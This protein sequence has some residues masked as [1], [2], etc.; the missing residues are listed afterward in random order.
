M[1][2][3]KVGVSIVP[4]VHHTVKFKKSQLS[5][6]Y[7]ELLIPKS[8]VTSPGFRPWTVGPDR[9]RD[10]HYNNIQSDLLLINYVHGQEDK[11]G[12]KLR[13]WDGTSPYHVNRPPRLPRGRVVETKD[14]KKRTWE[15]VPEITGVSINIFSEAAKTSVEAAIAAKLQLQQIT[16]MKPKTVKAKTDSS[17]LK[18]RKGT[19]V[20][21]SISLVGRPMNQFLSTLTDIVLPRSK[22]FAGIKNSAGDTNGNITFG[23][24]PD[25]VRNFPELENATELWPQTF[26][27]DI[28]IKT[29]AQ[30][31]H[32][33]RTLL[34]AYGFLF[35]G[36]E[37]FPKRH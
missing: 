1:S 18:L 24:T 11:P 19:P 20:G 14:V 26:G 2:A 6:R 13:E 9:I 23:L 5:S 36:P 27:M 15:N 37:R 8:N 22:T 10:H 28:T 31:D 17:A 3:G 34:S 32:E 25:D 33:A 12:L 4:P 16:G 21:A 7:R 35:T 30:L 29:T